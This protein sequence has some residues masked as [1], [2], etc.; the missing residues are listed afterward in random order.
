MRGV[1]IRDGTEVGGHGGLD[2]DLAKVLAA[3]GRAAGKSRWSCSDLNFVSKD[4]KVLPLL[5]RASSVGQPVSGRELIESADQ[6]QQVI[7]GQFTGVDEEGDAWVVIRAVDSSWWE[8]WSDNQW[9]HDAILAHFRV[10][11]SI[12]ES[13]G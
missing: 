5:E 3:L 9:V 1:K 10:V 2:F 8:V 6:V 4:D 11:E 12:P 7:D 13:A